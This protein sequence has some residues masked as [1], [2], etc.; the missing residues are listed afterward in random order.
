M[1]EFSWPVRIYYE[2]TD[3]GGVVYYANYLKFMERCRTEWLRALGF[4][5]S[6][7][8]QQGTIFA[9]RHIALN[10]RL[11]ARFNDTLTV[12]ARLSRLGRASVDF[13]QTVHRNQTILCDGEVKVAALDPD[14]F[15]PRP[16]GAT[17]QSR[18]QEVL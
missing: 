3:S 18:L 1:N 2:D 11:P 6:D 13:Y 14:S 4:E 16:L 9:V 7:L 15:K 10:Y 8:R 17:L 5:Q 12:T